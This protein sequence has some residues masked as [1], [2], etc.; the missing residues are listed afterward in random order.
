MAPCHN[1]ESEN[2]NTVV[3]GRVRWTCPSKHNVCEVGTSIKS[4]LR[5]VIDIYTKDVGTPLIINVHGHWS[6]QLSTMHIILAT[7]NCWTKSKVCCTHTSDVQGEI[8]EIKIIKVV[9]NK[10]LSRLLDQYRSE[11]F[12]NRHKF[13]RLTRFTGVPSMEHSS[14]FQF[15]EEHVSFWHFCFCEGVPGEIR[16]LMYDFYARCLKLS[17]HSLTG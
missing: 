11:R 17:N 10:A 9:L 12:L 6:R 2:L 8:T 15:L 13:V 4:Q 7:L 1:F 3:I 16:Q 14:L 5:A